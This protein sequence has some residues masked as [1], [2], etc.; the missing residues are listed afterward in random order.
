[1]W[2]GVGDKKVI[3]RLQGS[4]WRQGWGDLET[5]RR[6]GTSLWPR[7]GASPGASI[8]FVPPAGSAEEVKD[9]MSVAELIGISLNKCFSVLHSMLPKHRAIFDI[10]CY[11]VHKHRTIF[12]CTCYKS[13]EQCL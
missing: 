10:P 8:C 13:K 7:G 11:I 6:R 4:G 12:D 2:S 5:A 3:V 1:M 9:T